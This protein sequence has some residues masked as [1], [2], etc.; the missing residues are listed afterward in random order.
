MKYDLKAPCKDC[1]FRTDVKPYLKPERAQEICE[2]LVQYQ[3]T[4]ACHK[5]TVPDD[6]DDSDNVATSSSQHCAGAMIM[7]EHMELPNQMMRIMER[8]GGYDR[9]KLKMDSPV[10]ESTDEMLE[11]Y[12]ANDSDYDDR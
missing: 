3:Q 9:R 5:T 10:Y 12:D 7:L 11:A 8:C 4:F 2:A 6:D 1:P